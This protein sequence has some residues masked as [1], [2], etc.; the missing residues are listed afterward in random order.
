MLLKESGYDVR[1]AP[2]G[3]TAVQAA[4][5]FRPDVVLLDIGLP[6]MD[7]YEVAKRIR[8]QPVLRSVVLVALTG[9]G[10]EADMQTSLQVGFDHHLVKP[11]SFKNVQQILQAS[12]KAK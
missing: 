2:D 9:Y 3:S 6:G 12:E 1:T 8:Q 4:L 11:I 5:D 7:G 10:Q